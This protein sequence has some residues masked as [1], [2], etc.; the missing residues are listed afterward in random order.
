MLVYL[1][2]F[3]FIPR[4]QSSAPWFTFTNLMHILRVLFCTWHS[5]WV[6]FGVMVEVGNL[7]SKRY[8]KSVILWINLALL[9]FRSVFLLHFLLCFPPII[10]RSFLHILSRWDENM[11]HMGRWPCSRPGLLSCLEA[12]RILTYWELNEAANTVANSIFKCPPHTDCSG[13]M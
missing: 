2:S 8:F 6:I 5:K 11:L 9:S 3:S 10:N 4:A 12:C 7:T 1:D 13:K